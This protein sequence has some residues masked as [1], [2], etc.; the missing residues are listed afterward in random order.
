KR[1]PRPAASS[2]PTTPEREGG[3]AP[4]LNA[5]PRC[6]CLRR[7]EVAHLVHERLRARSVRPGVVVVYRFE[8]A[9]QFLL[10][11]SE[12]HRR[13]QRDV[14]IQIAGHRPANGTDTL[15]TQPENLTGL[16]LRGNL[17]LG[18]AV[19]RGNLDLAAQRRNGE[20][21]RHFTMQ[22]RGF[23]LEHRVRL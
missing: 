16:S 8:L 18:V 11:R 22:I 15:V 5:S 7:E 10:P 23:A 3:S 2:I 13:F 20:A 14:T 9:E 4:R 17:D 1:S 6:T 12:L 21:D 19:E